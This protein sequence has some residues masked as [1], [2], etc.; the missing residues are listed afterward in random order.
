MNE[1]VVPGRNGQV[2]VTPFTS[3]GKKFA[4]GVSRHHRPFYDDYNTAKALML[5]AIG[6][7]SEMDVFGRNVVCAIFVRPNIT[8]AGIILPLKEIKEDWYQ[9][10][11]VLVLKCGPDAFSG[12]PAYHDSMFGTAPIPKVGDWL[13]ANANA[14]IQIN[15]A[16]D[17][18]SR[19]Q[20]KDF[21][22]DDI[23]IFE[24]DGW[25]CRIIPDDQF[26]GRLE[27]PHEIV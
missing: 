21:N 27:R 14:G 5:Q 10:K 7:L 4:E 6:D 23:D 3:G 13:F 16:G 1:M 9:H 22:G 15:L 20:G 25:P 8:P 11:V 2:A 26:L 12:T 19:P 18:A 17:G 24:W